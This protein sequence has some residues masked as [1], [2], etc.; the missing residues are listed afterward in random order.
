MTSMTSA[1]ALCLLFCL[2][3]EWNI[4]TYAV[5]TIQLRKA[6]NKNGVFILYLKFF[7]PCCFSAHW[8]LLGLI[9]DIFINFR[10]SLCL[11]FLF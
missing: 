9:H 5:S 6:Q 4:S 11:K 3:N 8:A 10:P 7:S 2:L 1:F